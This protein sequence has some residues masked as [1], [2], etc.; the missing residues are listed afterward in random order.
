MKKKI[1]KYTANKNSEFAKR[2]AEIIK[3]KEITN[4]KAATICGIANS[5]FDSW[6]S[7]SL[8]TNFK[9]IKKLCDELNLSFTW[10]LTGEHEKKDHDPSIVEMFEEVPFFSGLARIRIDRLLP[11]KKQ[12]KE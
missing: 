3:E 2:L 11:R 10:L 8:P 1:N 12:D 9:A 6:L 4:K 7:G 5:T